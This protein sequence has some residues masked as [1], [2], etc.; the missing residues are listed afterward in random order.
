MDRE[1]KISEWFHLYSDDV[2]HFLL[3]RMGT[4][5]VED[6]VQEVFIKAIKGIDY[7]NGNSSPKTWLFTIARNV[8]V[9]EMRKRKWKKW[10]SFDSIQEPSDTNTPETIWSKN[11]SQNEIYQ[12]IISLKPTYRDVVIL[13]GIKDLSVSETASVLKWNENKVRITYHRAKILLRKELGGREDE[14]Y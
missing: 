13:R 3:Y 7:F 1:E 5:E 4:T 11:E 8:A 9:D 10:T 2:Y 12:A 14:A 6:L